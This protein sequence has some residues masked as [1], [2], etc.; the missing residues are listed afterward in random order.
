MVLLGDEARNRCRHNA[1]DEEGYASHP[2]TDECPEIALGAISLTLA[3]QVHGTRR[4]GN[5][6]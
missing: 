5:R 2:R 6:V 1:E 3:E 4:P